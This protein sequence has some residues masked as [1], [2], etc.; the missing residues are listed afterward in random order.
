MFGG[1]GLVKRNGNDS[2]QRAVFEH[3]NDAQLTPDQRARFCYDQGI[4]PTCGVKTHWIGP[5]KRRPYTNNKVKN[6]ICVTCYPQ[7]AQAQTPAAGD[8]ARALFS[9][10][11]DAISTFSE[12]INSTVTTIS[13][14]TT[15]TFQTATQ[16]AQKTAE[17]ARNSGFPQFPFSA[18][19]KQS[20]QS[21]ESNT[22]NT[23]F[24]SLKT[25]YQPKN[26]REENGEN[27]Q[28]QPKLLKKSSTVDMKEDMIG[29]NVATAYGRGKIIGYRPE[30]DMFMIDL[31]STATSTTS[32]DTNNNSSTK[33]KNTRLF[34][35]VD[36]FSIEQDKIKIQK[37]A[38]E[39]NEAYEAME[40]MRRLNFEVACG[41]R[42][43]E[44]DFEQCVICLL[45]TDDDDNASQQKAPEEPK[46]FPRIR[47]FMKE[48]S[49]KRDPEPCLF[50][51]NPCCQDHSSEEFR[52]EGIAACNDCVKIFQPEYIVNCVNSAHGVDGGSDDKAREG[53]VDHMIDLYDRVLLLLQYS[54]Q[55]V[56]PLAE[57]LE[58]SKK[59]AN[60]AN[61][62]GS[63]AGIISGALGVAA[64]ATL[65]TPAGAPLLVASL[66]LGGSATA[67][68]TGTELG[69]S[70]FSEPHKVAGRLIALYGML[71]N[72]LRVKE[73]LREVLTAK[74]IDL[75]DH[76]DIK[77]YKSRLEDIE[78]KKKET[79]VKLGARMGSTALM[80]SFAGAAVSA[81]S[82]ALMTGVEVGGMNYVSKAGT[83]LARGARFARGF[84]GALSAATILLE[85]RTMSSTMEQIRAGNPCDKANTIRA[86]A[87]ELPMLPTTKEI[88]DECQIYLGAMSNRVN[89]PSLE[90]AMRLIES[91]AIAEWQLAKSKDHQESQEGTPNGGADIAPAEASIMDGDEYEQDDLELWE[92]TLL[93]E[94][95]MSRSLSDLPKKDETVSQDDPSTVS[96]PPRLA[97]SM[98][99][100]SSQS[101]S[102]P[103]MSQSSLL[104]RI[105]KFKEQDNK[106]E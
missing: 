54:S 77:M 2:K 83:G 97:Q 23:V 85:A 1:G 101:S 92:S 51:A 10:T 105:Q 69:V 35:K 20:Q 102:P 88:D 37:R 106:S 39:L 9:K 57:A 103:T 91:K 71:H 74:L 94:R 48:N 21:Q 104:E 32:T 30:D 29:K 78:S 49:R 4:C 41:E 28:Q 98:M 89:A 12:S 90:D 5:F 26:S 72:L 7:K 95:Q 33:G 87:K 59:K 13:K 16:H 45:G 8:G 11:S 70:Y 82:A 15:D 86:I 73:T 66:V 14:T 47:K 67:V 84:G 75:Q 81:E 53:Q 18:S 19:Q 40:K 17:Q 79:A 62:T 3:L 42:G 76:D 24:D 56:D 68:Q 50:C 64:A 25:N 43:V 55:Y 44:V 80:G 36:S 65:L 99:Q 6:G 22:K 31:V 34:C 58:E 52:K 60:T 93:K 96:A 27:T 61:M 63:S 100:M 38:M 46:N